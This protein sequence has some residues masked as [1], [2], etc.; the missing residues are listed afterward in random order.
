M[1]S[2][3]FLLK[4]NFFKKNFVSQRSGIPIYNDA[5]EIGAGDVD[6]MMN[7]IWKIVV[8]SGSLERE[9]IVEAENVAWSA[10]IPEVANNQIDKFVQIFDIKGKRNHIPSSISSDLLANLRHKEV[11]VV[12]F[13]YSVPIS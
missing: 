6:E 8:E 9:V 5:K 11:H 13:I 2:N 12:V 4:N 7:N 1:D 3:L 10:D